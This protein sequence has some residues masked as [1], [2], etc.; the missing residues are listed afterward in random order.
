MVMVRVLR[1]HG[2]LPAPELTTT[3]P[4]LAWFA[5]HLSAP[6]TIDRPGVRLVRALT[7]LG[8]TAIKLGQVLSTRPDLIGEVAASDLALLQDRLPPFSAAEARQTISQS[9]GRPVEALFATFDDRPVAA[10]SIAQV[11]FAQTPDGQ[12]VAVKILRPGIEEEF[13]Q[14]L[15]LLRWLAAIASRWLPGMGRLKLPEIV[16]VFA[17]TAQSEMDLRMEGAAAAELRA[18]FAENDMFRVPLVDWDRTARRILTIEWFDG[19]R[20]DDK[21][22]VLALGLDVTE[23]LT[24]ASRAFFNQ[25]FRDGF[26]H[27]D[28]HPGNMFVLADGAI[29]VVDFG[30]MGRLDL[31]TR[32]YLADILLGFLD[33]D[34][35]RVARLHFDAGYVP[36]GQSPE[37]FTQAVRAIGEPLHNKTLDQISVGRLLAQLF[38]VT[39]QFQMET[40]P[41]LLLLQKSILTAEGVGRQLDPSVNIWELARPLIETWMLQHRGPE[42]IAAGLAAQW[43][44]AFQELPTLIGKLGRIAANMEREQSIGS[45]RNRRANA[46]RRLVWRVWWASLIGIVLYLFFLA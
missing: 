46:C 42:A 19:V 43:V 1:R 29:G 7:A 17:Q 4:L 18:N 15:D 44:R 2:L 41:Q 45:V 26:F 31:T 14:D 8:P 5:R 3:S 10:A 34:Y 35:G 13:Q 12:R 37:L 6:A 27:A 38:E 24:A 9:L 32:R 20:F 22:A 25:V 36:S 28:L 11:H 39:R 21:A 30:I 33:R 40:Q 23:I 16:N